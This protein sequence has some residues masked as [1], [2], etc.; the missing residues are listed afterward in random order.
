MTASITFVD[1]LHLHLAVAA[2]PVQI[3]LV[4]HV[5]A[6][7]LHDAGW[8]GDQIQDVVFVVSEAVSNSVEHAY[9]GLDAGRVAVDLTCDADR[10]VVVVTDQGSWRP[11]APVQ[12]RGSGL[13]LI[14]TLSESVEV[15]T[16]VS[17]TRVT[18]VCVSAPPADRYR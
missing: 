9:R 2:E 11:D 3:G 1:D 18:V 5:A 14:R 15:A 12:Q 7:F 16:G 13:D 6:R 17:G 4:R 10:V 8:P